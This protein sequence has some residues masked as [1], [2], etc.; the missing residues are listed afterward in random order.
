MTRRRWIA[1]E[2]SGDRAALLG[3][4]AAHLARVLRARIGQ[5]FDIS[6]GERVRRGTVAS[7]NEARV[8]FNLAEDVP[9]AAAPEVIVL[10]SIFKFDRMEWAVEKLAELG[11]VRIVPLMARRSES[12]LTTAAERRVERWRRIA[13]E[14][15]QQ[16]RRVAPPEISSPTRL[17][18]ALAVGAATRIVLSEAED[19]TSL[20]Q[21]L[22][23]AAA[24]LALA[25]GPEGGWAEDELRLF[26]DAGWRSASLGSTI[27]RAETAAIAA[28]AIA[29]AEL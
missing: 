23:G 2:V 16:A 19:Q 6:T 18:D 10:L 22:A 26:A 9:L 25:F 12:H 5:Q 7:V 13:R 8:E 14:A 24:P 20:K 17:Q 1:D 4:Q 21:A 29:L 11:A 28:V 27:L 3:D 15:A